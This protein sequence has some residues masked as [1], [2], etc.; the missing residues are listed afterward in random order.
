ML[1]PLAIETYAHQ[2]MRDRLLEIQHDALV[3]QLPRTPST[4]AQARA[5]LALGLR[6]IARRL[7]PSVA[8]EVRLVVARTR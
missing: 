4:A 3:A 2:V 7:D 8:P 6:S 1:S 5:H